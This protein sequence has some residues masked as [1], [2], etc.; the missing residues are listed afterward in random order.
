[1]QFE[2]I[3]DDSALKAF[4]EQASQTSAIAV[5][6]EFVRTRTLY[7]ILGLIQ[8]YDGESLVLVDPQHINDFSPLIDLMKNDSVVKVLHS[9]SEDLETFWHSLKVIPRPLFDTQFAA[10]L[11]GK[12]ATL[13]YA[14]LVEMMLGVKLDKGESRTDWTAR[15]LSPQQCQYAAN[16]VLYLLQLYPELHNDIERAGRLD[17]VYA[18]MQHLGQKKQTKMPAELAYLG[19]KNNWQVHGRSLY[20]LKE[21]AKWRI[22]QARERDMA[23]N[24]VVREPNLVAIAKKRPQSKGALFNLDGM[25]PQEARIHGSAL[26]KLVE[27]SVDVPPELYPSAVERLNEFPDYKKV[28]AA[29]RTLCL[30]VAEQQQIPVEIIGSKKQINQVLKWLWFDLDETREMGL[31]PDLLCGW[32]KPLLE[33]G[34]QDI[35]GINSEN[36]G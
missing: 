20:L 1:M 33:K 34:I 13:G 8:L 29:I 18:E 11:L 6:T 21:L 2:L 10:C 9:C 7:P 36:K 27:E 5:D 26:L 28:A 30:D 32:R 31:K 17:W 14:N 4:C 22:E 3:T 12:G 25:T 15:P 16:D 19:V 35:T 23:L 24:F